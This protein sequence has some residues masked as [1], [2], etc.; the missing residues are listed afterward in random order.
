M[1]TSFDQ[2]SLLEYLMYVVFCIILSESDATVYR[3]KLFLAFGMCMLLF[4]FKPI[5]HHQHGSIYF[6]IV[7]FFFEVKYIKIRLLQFS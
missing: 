2:S 7:F 6:S 5:E 1:S 4:G 3:H